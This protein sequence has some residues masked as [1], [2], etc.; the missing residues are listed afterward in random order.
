M[1]ICTWTR[2]VSMPIS[3][4]LDEGNVKTEER[5]EN[6]TE[7]AG[8]E[9]QVDTV[10]KATASTSSE[11]KTSA[12]VTLTEADNFYRLLSELSSEES[13][14]TF[15]LQSPAAAEKLS[16]MSDGTMVVSLTRS[17]RSR[18]TSRHIPPF[19]MPATESPRVTPCRGGT[20]HGI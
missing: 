14:S 2:H 19:A 20:A 3:G 17:S 15:D 8:A 18:H 12:V 7:T 5:S 11:R 10:G 6:S 4:Q 9:L 16:S 13:L 1:S